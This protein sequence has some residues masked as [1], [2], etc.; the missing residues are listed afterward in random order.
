ME[1]VVQKC[2][3]SYEDDRKCQ[4]N[5]LSVS[6]KCSDD[7]TFMNN[8]CYKNCPTGFEDYKLYCL[9]SKYKDRQI[10]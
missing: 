7:E 2:E 1:K 4:V 3:D 5:N 9:K 10:E 6:L 8:A